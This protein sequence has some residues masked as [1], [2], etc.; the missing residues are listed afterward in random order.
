MLLLLLLLL[1]LFY[2]KSHCCSKH[3]YTQPQSL[4]RCSGASRHKVLVSVH[5][6]TKTQQRNT[7]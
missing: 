4:S 1:L 3:H 6:V 5:I 2:N 7:S